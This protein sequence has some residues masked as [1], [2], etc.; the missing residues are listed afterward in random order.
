MTLR[1]AGAILLGLLGC[2]FAFLL[3]N[4]TLDRFRSF[5]SRPNI[6]P[7]G[8]LNQGLTIQIPFLDEDVDELLE[9]AFHITLVV[10]RLWKRPLLVLAV[11]SVQ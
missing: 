8:N 4:V 10:V 3:R 5:L 1:E 9:F 6:A 7:V 11:W 2:S